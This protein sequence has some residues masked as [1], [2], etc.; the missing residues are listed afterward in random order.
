MDKVIAALTNEKNIKSAR[1]HPLTILLAATT[2]KEGKGFRGKLKWNVNEKIVNALEQAFLLAFHNIVP[3][4]KRICIGLDVSGKYPIAKR[5]SYHFREY[6]YPDY[7][8]PF[9]LSA[10]V[11]C[12]EHDF[13]E[14]GAECDLHGVPIRVPF[15]A[16][17][18]HL[19]HGKNYRVRR[20]NGYRRIL[21]GLFP[22]DDVG[23]RTQE[24][25]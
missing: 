7:E 23:R 5:H 3:T 14:V 9:E 21:D 22:T 16:F 12:H 15:V 13:L 20:S 24:G 4:N 18:Q 11:V 10:G 19:E 25:V 2:Y 1:V 8:Y 17:R 6:V